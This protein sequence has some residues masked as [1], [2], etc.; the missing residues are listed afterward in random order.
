MPE[1]LIAVQHQL[2]YGFDDLSSITEAAAGFDQEHITATPKYLDSLVASL[3][4]LLRCSLELTCIKPDTDDIP[5][6][7]GALIS[8]LPDLNDV[9]HEAEDNKPAPEPVKKKGSCV[10]S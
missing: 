6:G 5:Y 4:R 9:G 8:Q 2:T 1:T 10:V 7:F 3:V